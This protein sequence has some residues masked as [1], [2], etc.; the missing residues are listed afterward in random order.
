MFASGT[1]RHVDS[2]ALDNFEQGLLNALAA[3]VAGDARVV[4]CLARDLVDLVDVDD[5]T[6][7]P[8]CIPVGSLEQTD[9]QAFDVF[10]HVSG[11]GQAGGIGDGEGNVEESGQ[12]LRHEGL[13]AARGAD[14]E[15]VAFGKLDQLLFGVL[16]VAR[17]ACFLF[18]AG[19]RD[20]VLL[21]LR[22]LVLAPALPCR[23]AAAEYPFIVV[24]DSD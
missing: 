15:H 17:G 24:V 10:A 14:Q 18:G 4:A 7:G 12:N 16:N 11:F 6:C 20:L 3:D 13:A 22:G 8:V 2:G 9:E 5:A 19:K 23:A 21:L 1:G